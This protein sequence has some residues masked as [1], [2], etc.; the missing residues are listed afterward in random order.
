[1][2]CGNVVFGKMI[3]EELIR[4]VRDEIVARSNANDR[5]FSKLLSRFSSRHKGEFEDLEGQ[6][7]D[8]CYNNIHY[9]PKDVNRFIRSLYERG[10]LVHEDEE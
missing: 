6:L 7:M 4:D 3:T 5:A 9:K 1:M 8:F 2:V 10:I